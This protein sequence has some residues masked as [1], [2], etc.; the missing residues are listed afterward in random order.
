MSR[1]VRVGVAA[2][3]LNLTSKCW[4]TPVITVASVSIRLQ[5]DWLSFFSLSLSEQRNARFQVNSTRRSREAWPCARLRRTLT[6]TT[7][8]RPAWKVNCT[9]SNL[10][11]PRPEEEDSFRLIGYRQNAAGPLEAWS[12]FSISISTTFSY[13][14]YST[15]YFL[16]YSY[17]Q[18]T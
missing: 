16:P 6:D 11:A 17:S 12:S 15:V 3:R 2:P 4:R 10:T 14:Y 18:S 8:Q 9:T 13:N 5:H 7:V 1:E